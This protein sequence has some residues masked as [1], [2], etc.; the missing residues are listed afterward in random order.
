MLARD[1]MTVNPTVVTPDDSIPRA[2]ALMAEMDVGL[3]PV[4]SELDRSRLLGVIT[5]RDITLRCV[6]EGHPASECL[7]RHHMTAA[8]IDTVTPESGVEHVLALM[9]R[10]QVRRIPVMEGGKLVGMISTADVAR[11]CGPRHAQQLEE[12]MEA[13]SA[14]AGA[15]RKPARK[16]VKHAAPDRTARG[17]KRTKAAR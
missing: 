12:M 16:A 14:P 6:A 17:R 8:P 9:E 4:V 1:I 7:V 13:I 15:A 3:V 11:H 2:A 10:D 5:D